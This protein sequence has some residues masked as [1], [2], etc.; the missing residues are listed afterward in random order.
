MR[1]VR[2]YSHFTDAET[3]DKEGKITCSGSWKK[4]CDWAMH[5]PSLSL[6]CEDKSPSL[7]LG[8]LKKDNG[9]KVR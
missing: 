9:C 1:W 2:Y 6:I 3:E 8:E 7:H 5:F 4:L